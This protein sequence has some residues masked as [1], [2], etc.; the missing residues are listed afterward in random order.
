MSEEE[1]YDLIFPRNR[2]GRTEIKSL[3]EIRRVMPTIIV[4]DEFVGVSPMVGPT[5][6]T[7]EL[8]RSLSKKDKQ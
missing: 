4:G 2:E 1:S 8:I 5:P 7:L 6:E 3:S